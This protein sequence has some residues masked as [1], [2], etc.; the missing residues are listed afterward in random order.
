V[1]T[2]VFPWHES[3]RNFRIT[4]L[5]GLAFQLGVM[6]LLTVMMRTQAIGTSRKARIALRVEAVLLSLA[7]IWSLLHAIAPTRDRLAPIGDHARDETAELYDYHRDMLLALSSLF[8]GTPMA[9]SVRDFLAASSRPQMG[10]RFN[11]VWE[12][13]YDGT[14]AAAAARLNTSYFASGTGHFFTR[15][16]WNP[17]STWLGFLT[18]AYTESHAHSD[19]LSLLLYKNGWLVNDANMQTHSGLAQSQ[20]AHALVRSRVAFYDHDRYFAPDIAA[21]QG[22]VEGGAFHR[23][24]PSVFPAARA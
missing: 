5:T 6:A 12:V 7:S 23:F 21:I 15:Y 24:V 19:G 1:T 3:E 18:G 2:V 11:W 17:Y 4:D 16:A 10:D 9:R 14:E 8:R 20:E 13:F 22:L